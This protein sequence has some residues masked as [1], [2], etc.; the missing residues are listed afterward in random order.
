MVA[1]VDWLP[2]GCAYVR[3]LK[4]PNLPAPGSKVRK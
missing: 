4:Q 1:R 3:H 2:A